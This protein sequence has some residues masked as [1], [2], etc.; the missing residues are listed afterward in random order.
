MSEIEETFPAY[1]GYDPREQGAF[2][3]CK[4]SLIRHSSWPL[5]VVELRQ[6]MLRYIGMYNRKFEIKDGQRTDAIDGKPFSTE[7]SFT[8][9]LVPALAQYQGWALFMDC[10]MLIRADLRGLLE[11]HCDPEKAVMVVK[12]D[13][14]PT[15]T[16][17]MDNQAQEVYPRKNWSSFM[18]WNCGHPANKNLT[19]EAVNTESGN[20]L[21]SFGWLKD[22]EIGAIDETWNWLEGWSQPMYDPSNVHFTRGVPDM[23]GYEDVPFADEYRQEKALIE[24]DRPT[25]RQR[26]ALAF[27]GG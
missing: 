22:D 27:T 25:A 5:F 20:W 9:F 14:R 16:V 4:H 3:V 21:H 2:D 15:E 24:N 18:L 6:P 12:H 23:A 13:Y 7:F 10:D 8:R 19:V 17:K 11:Q 26:N 1:I